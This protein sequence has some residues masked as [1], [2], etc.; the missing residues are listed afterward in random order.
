MNKQNKF[1]LN[2]CKKTMNEQNEKS[3]TVP[4]LILGIGTSGFLLVGKTYGD[5]AMGSRRTILLVWQEQDQCAIL[6]SHVLQL[7]LVCGEHQETIIQL[8]GSARHTRLH[9]N[10]DIRLVCHTMGSIMNVRYRFYLVNRVSI[11]LYFL[12]ILKLINVKLKAENLESWVYYGCNQ[13]VPWTD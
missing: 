3:L 1:L 11:F 9:M 7:S 4:F 5:R 12:L 6:I 10:L 2:D 13:R 8:Q